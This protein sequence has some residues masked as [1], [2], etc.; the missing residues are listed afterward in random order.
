MKYKFTRIF[1]AGQTIISLIFAP[2]LAYAEGLSV[3]VSDAV[4]EEKEAGLF[5]ITAISTDFIAFGLKEMATQLLLEKIKEW[6]AG[7]FQGS[8]IFIEN[9]EQFFKDVAEEASGVFVE[10]LGTKLTGDPNFF[11]SN[12]IPNFV[13]DIGE[14]GRKRVERR[15]QC[16][17]NRV[18]NNVEGQL[19]NFYEDFDN[20]RLGAYLEL[21]QMQNNR[22]MT[23]FELMDETKRRR[24]QAENKFKDASQS[25]G[26]YFPNIK[27]TQRTAKFCKQWTIKTP[28]KA[29]ADRITKTV[30]TDLEDIISTDE[31]TELIVAI[32]A[33]LIKVALEEGLSN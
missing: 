23:Y 28:A 11:C 29:I 12:I 1:I 7:G 15:A 22:Y 25:S 2:F 6:A 16:T 9:P 21:Q 13:L 8:P 32:F 14:T 5:G 17:M 30:G 19:N 26:G 24:A 10:E 33:G 20:G 18:F 3:P 31:I 27:C 4:L